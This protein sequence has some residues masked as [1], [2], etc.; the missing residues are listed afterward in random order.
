M[1]E[2]ERLAARLYDLPRKEALAHLN[3]VLTLDEGDDQATRDAHM[4]YNVALVTAV[5]KY[6]E[7]TKQP[8]P[9]I[10]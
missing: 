6:G 8:A 2:I 7:T 1:S 4:A 9:W 5:R 10:A 3:D